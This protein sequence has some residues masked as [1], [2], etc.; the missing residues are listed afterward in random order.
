M[1][2]SNVVYRIKNKDG[3]YSTGG[4]H[5]KFVKRGGKVWLSLA[6]IKLHLRQFSPKYRKHNF[7]ND[8]YNN[9][10]E[11]FQT[12]NPIPKDWVIIELGE[13]AGSERMAYGI[14][15]NEV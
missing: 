11:K 5:P 3:L 10:Y 7:S 1:R 6:A 2:D 13:I 14:L 12:K 4:N 8:E 15:G 9:V